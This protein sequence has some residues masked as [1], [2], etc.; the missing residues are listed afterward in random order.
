MGEEVRLS[1]QAALEQLRQAVRRDVE[2]LLNARRRRRPL[3]ASLAELAISPL[4]YGVPDPTAGS[5]TTPESRAAL[6]Q[7]IEDTLR[8]F[9]PRLERISVTLAADQRD[10]M[11]RSLRLRIDATLRV[12]PDPEFVT[13]ETVLEPATLDITVLER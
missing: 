2:A 11:D 8:R 13:F 3:P 12:K 6:A 4:G 5:F 1:R 10:L 7:E 9:E